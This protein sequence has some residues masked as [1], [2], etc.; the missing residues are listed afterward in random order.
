VQT[1]WRGLRVMPVESV[2][3][4]LPA[5]YTPLFTASPDTKLITLAPYNTVVSNAYAAQGNRLREFV[6]DVYITDR[7]V[8]AANRTCIAFDTTFTSINLAASPQLYLRVASALRPPPVTMTQ[9][10]AFMAANGLADGRFVSLHLRLADIAGHFH[11]D[12]F[13]PAIA[14]VVHP[15]LQAQA[16]QGP[17]GLLPPGQP[18]PIAIATD[19]PGHAH[20]Q[21]AVG[22]IAAAVVGGGGVRVVRVV[23]ASVPDAHSDSCK[24]GGFIHEVLAR[25][26]VFV[27]T[28]SSSYSGAV[29]ELRVTAYH[30]GNHTH[31]LAGDR[32]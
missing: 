17:A 27:G 7:V 2:N 6:A 15:W 3:F 18:V 9:V 13:L 30:K 8:A 19:D 10:D 32:G 11:L 21:A 12:T 23:R 4:P 25:G 26:A 16:A 24:S 5:N 1:T 28:W 20:E 29:K 14:R 31:E 22:A